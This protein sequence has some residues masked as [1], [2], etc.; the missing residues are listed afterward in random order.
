MSAFLYSIRWRVQAWHG[1][2]LFVVILAFCLTA[3]RLAWDNQLRRI[4]RDLVR[5]DRALFHALLAR[6]Q[7][8]KTG[9]ADDKN[10]L[11]PGRLI[12]MLRA[13]PPAIPADQAAVFRGTEPGYAYFSLRDGEGQTL[14]ESPNV[15]ADLAFLPAVPG[16]FSEEIRTREGRRESLRSGPDRLRSVVGVDL[17]PEL[18]SLHRFALSLAAVGLGVWLLGLLGG[19]WL[20][21]RAIRPIET[22]SRTAT[23]I[24]DGNLTERIDTTGTDSELDQLSH[25]LNRT[26]DRLHA[27]FERQKQFTADA[28][29]ELRT[30]VTVLLAET[31]R[32][33]KRD[34][35]AEEYRAVIVTCQDHAVRMRQLTE[36]L[37]LLARQESAG[38]AQPRE[39]CDLATLLGDAAARLQPLADARQLRLQLDL[40]PAPCL[41]DPAALSMLAGNLVANA[42]QHHDR[43]GGCVRLACAQREGRAVCSVSDDGPGIPPAD[44]P[45][46]FER[47]YRVD[48]SRTGRSGHTGLGLAIA[49]TIVENHAGDITAT[50]NPDRGVCFSVRLPGA[51]PSPSCVKESGGS[52]AG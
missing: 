31:Q 28:S 12:E 44:L 13:G 19:W 43:P 51:D 27:A 5:V 4:D 49:K 11:P 8:G 26:F 1:L 36:S 23:R 46:I 15:P 48:K 37:L 45:H 3:Y 16:D 30:P 6:D 7:A 2:I 50:N 34:R 18:E 40:H 39:A 38:P 14:L 52:T 25:V 29:H 32:I 22:I 17:T 35:T 24:A 33:L 42:I 9:P 47:F 20:A 10:P 41:G 21:G